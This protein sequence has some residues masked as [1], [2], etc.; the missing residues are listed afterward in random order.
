MIYL[1]VII[2]LYKLKIQFAV[3]I[4]DGAINTPGKFLEYVTIKC[5]IWMHLYSPSKTIIKSQLRQLLRTEVRQEYIINTEGKIK[6]IKSMASN[7]EGEQDKYS[8]PFPFHAHFWITMRMETIRKAQMAIKK[9]TL[10]L[11]RSPELSWKNMLIQQLCYE[12]MFKRFKVRNI[13]VPVKAEKLCKPN[14][15]LGTKSFD[16]FLRSWIKYQMQIKS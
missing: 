9:V 8:N 7:W 13:Q 2:R 10:T 11:K 3:W 12:R 6:P 15:H 16:C 14:S 5:F 1:A 4:T